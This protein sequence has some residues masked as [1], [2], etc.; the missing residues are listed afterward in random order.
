M[1]DCLMIGM[2]I[3]WDEWLMNDVNDYWMI[4]MSLKWDEWPKNDVD[5]CQWYEWV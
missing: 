3:K 1:N 2:S 4:G 5:D